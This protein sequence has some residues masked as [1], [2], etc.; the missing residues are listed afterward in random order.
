MMQVVRDGTQQNGR[1]GC[2][3]ENNKEVLPVV[4]NIT[5]VQFRY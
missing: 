1:P 5:L 3:V 4:E 2:M